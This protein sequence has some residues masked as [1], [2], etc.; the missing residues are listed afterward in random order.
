MQIQQLVSG[1]A[2]RKLYSLTELLKQLWINA[3]LFVCSSSRE[4]DLQLLVLSCLLWWRETLQGRQAV[5]VQLMTIGNHSIMSLSPSC[6]S[7]KANLR[8]ARSV[9]HILV[10][11][12]QMTKTWRLKRVAV[13]YISPMKT[14]GF[15]ANWQLW[16]HTFAISFCI[17]MPGASQEFR[18]GFL[19]NLNKFR[20]NIFFKKKRNFHTKSFCVPRDFLNFRNFEPNFNHRE[21]E[22]NIPFVQKYNNVK[23]NGMEHISCCRMSEWMKMYCLFPIVFLQMELKKNNQMRIARD[24]IHF[25]YISLHAWA[26]YLEEL[27]Q[28]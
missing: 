27:L 19:L 21:K 28:F 13:S 17:F 8:S 6:W 3:W 12:D 10:Q 7:S 18:M 5:V 15:Y 1:V 24:D 16:V 11:R 9:V 4:R 23:S 26:A 20:L 2:G 25:H 14:S 22:K